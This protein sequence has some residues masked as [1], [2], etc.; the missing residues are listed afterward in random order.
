MRANHATNGPEPARRTVGGGRR[1]T[2]RWLPRPRTVAAGGALL[3]QLWGFGAP[4]AC[5]AGTEPLPEP[6]GR[7]VGRALTGDG[8]PAD[9]PSAGR[10]ADVRGGGPAAPTARTPSAEPGPPPVPNPAG[11]NPPAGLLDGLPDPAPGSTP[12]ARTP[13]AVGTTPEPDG[14]PLT[15]SGVLQDRIRAGGLPLPGQRAAVPDA[16]AIA[17]GLLSTV[18]A[19]SRPTEARATRGEPAD[20]SSGGS[21]RVGEG[22]RTGR[23][24]GDQHRPAAPPPAPASPDHS[25]APSAGHPDPAGTGSG[26]AAGREGSPAAAGAPAFGTA[27]APA[28]R[29]TTTAAVTVAHDAAGTATAVL[30][31]IAA[32]LVLTG[33][34]MYKHRGLPKGH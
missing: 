25:Q 32:G 2:R 11:Q 22:S 9:G 6:A 1:P 12:S 20:G 29:T 31:P 27:A 26:P 28:G 34:A 13:E 30:A 15:V 8:A 7:A 4:G 23:T 18:P 3:A 24:G 21:A 17:F 33:A 5:A 14:A 10:P 16:F 19:Q